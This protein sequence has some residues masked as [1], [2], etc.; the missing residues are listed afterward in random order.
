MASCVT[1]L[2][3]F[4]AAAC[5]VPVVCAMEVAVAEACCACVMRFDPTRNVTRMMRR[6][7]PMATGMIHRAGEEADC[8]GAPIGGAYAP[9]G[10]APVGYAPVGYAPGGNA[11]GG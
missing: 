4:V 11:P 2:A 1:S 6:A 3:K 8:G 10:Y 7:A 9:V 5:A